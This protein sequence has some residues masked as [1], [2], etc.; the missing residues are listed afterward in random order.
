[1]KRLIVGF[2]LLGLVGCFLPLVGGAA[3]FDFRHW[4][5]WPIYLILAGFVVP[6]IAALDDKL[7]PLRCLA[8]LIGFGYVAVKFNTGIWDLVIH[9]EI[10]GKM[11]G[12]AAVGGLLASLGS[13]AETRKA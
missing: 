13:F 3:L 1:M 9:A 11:M 8:A 5:A 10:G 2:A 4:D 7:T 12:V 6:L